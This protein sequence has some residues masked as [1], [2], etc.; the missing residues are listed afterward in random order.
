MFS[1]IS[2]RSRYN[3]SRR[4]GV[5]RTLRSLRTLSRSRVAL[6]QL[7]KAQLEDIGVTP[8]E[9]RNEASRKVWDVPQHWRL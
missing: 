4:A 8:E 3:N 9:A 7:N 5:L 2:D 6:S 1:L